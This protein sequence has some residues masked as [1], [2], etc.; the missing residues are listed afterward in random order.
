M[1]QFL[2]TPELRTETLLGISKE[3]ENAPAKVIVFVYVSLLYFN[4]CSTV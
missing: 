1:M 2:V 4:V 3:F